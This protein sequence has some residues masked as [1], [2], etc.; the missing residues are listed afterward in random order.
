MEIP[1]DWTDDMRI[2]VSDKRELSAIVESVLQKLLDHRPN[3]QCIEELIADHQISHDDAELAMDRIQGGVIRAL[4]GN[5]AN[6][7]DRIK[8][9]LAWLAF[10]SV[11]L[12]FPRKH[13]FTRKRLP[14]GR[15]VSWRGQIA[16][17]S[18]HG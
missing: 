2:A 7:P 1:A 15:W 6:R 11:W 12:E 17:T 18:N 13:F 5:P 16:T 4:T 14:Q 9:H 10:K 8:D 3:D